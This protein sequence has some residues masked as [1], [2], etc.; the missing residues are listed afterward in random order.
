MTNAAIYARVSTRDKGQTNDNQL[1]ELRAFTKRLGYIILQIVLQPEKRPPH[2]LPR[3]RPLSGHH[4]A[5]RLRQQSRLLC[6]CARAMRFLII[7]VQKK[8][9]HKVWLFDATAAPDFV[10]KGR[11]KYTAL[12]R[13]H[14]RHLRVVWLASAQPCRS[15]E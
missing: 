12:P 10:A 9:S 14:S 15:V 13:H 7:G 1:L 11:N 8:A 2:Q 5:I 4:R 3:I 6:Q